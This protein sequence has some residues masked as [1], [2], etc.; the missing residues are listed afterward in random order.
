MTTIYLV[1]H[2]STAWNEN[3]RFRGLADLALS[4]KG[5]QQ[6]AALARMLRNKPLSAVYSSPL[7][8]AVQTADVLA[9]VHGLR[10]QLRDGFKSVDYGQWEGKTEQEVQGSDPELYAQFLNAIEAVRF[11]G[12]ESMEEMRT[13]AF[14]ALQEIA[15]SHA[16]QQVA[17]VTHQVVTRVLICAVLGI[18]SH[19]YWK[20]GQD[21]A[22]LNILE[23]DGGFRLKLMNESPENA[24]ACT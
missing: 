4:D 18:D 15:G 3:P 8:R 24:W 10:V 20:L 22:C 9:S 21:P 1:R 13:R 17:V 19:A 6:A 16:G 2:G 11:P 5:N 12:G 14:C 7:R 23:F